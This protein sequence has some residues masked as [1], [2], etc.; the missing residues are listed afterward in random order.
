MDKAK[1]NRLLML[2]NRILDSRK[3]LVLMSRHLDNTDTDFFRY[4]IAMLEQEVEDMSRQIRYMKGECSSMEDLEP[5]YV[6][7]EYVVTEPANATATAKTE[8]SVSREVVASSV[9]NTSSQIMDT[10]EIENTYYDNFN[11]SVKTSTQEESNHD[12]E[13]TFGKSFMGIAASVLIFI[14]IVLFATLL[15]PMFGD[16]AKMAIMYAVSGAFL[17]IGA[18]RLNK[19]KD[20][21][22]NIALTGCGFGAMFISLL[23]S[24]IYFEVLGDIPLYVMI[25]IWGVI[26]CIFAKNKNFVFQI[27]GE[28]GIIVATVF[29]CILCVSGKDEARFLALL[30]FYGITSA[31][32]YFVNYEKEYED[33]I[34]YHGFAAIGGMVLTIGCVGI[35]GDNS[36]VCMIIAL[37]IQILNIVG[38][39][40]HRLD[41]PQISFGVITSLELFSV[42]IISLYV[43]E[44]EKIWGLVTYLIGMIMIFAVSMKK[45]NSKSG[46]ELISG[47]SAIVALIGLGANGTAYNYGV[48]FLM[49]IPLLVY[50]YVRKYSIS[51]Y[52]GLAIMGVYM[53]IYDGDIRGLHFVLMLVAFAV[54]YICMF[55]FKDQYNKEYKSLLHIGALLLIVSQMGDALWEILG[56]E[57]S[58]LDVVESI[59][60]VSFFVLNTICYKSRFVSNSITGEK[61]ENKEI[62][63][64]ANVFA[65]AMG[66]M[67]ISEPGSMGCH[68][69]NIL[70]ALAAFLIDTK[71]ILNKNSENVAGNVYIGGKF[72]VLLIVVLN[73]FTSPNYVISIACLV[74]A[75]LLILAGFKGEYKY[76]RIYGLGLTMISIFKLLM[77][78]I[79][80]A[81]TLGN[82][83]SFFVSGVLCFAISMIYN[84]LDKKMKR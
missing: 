1:L 62:Y 21:R 6:K 57:E 3:S 73:S 31:I 66:C 15:L 63:T 51:K 37:I 61:D 9:N 71:K 77:V 5:R 48:V 20:D 65:M 26:I 16:E 74:L 36:L 54:A 84:Y 76:L 56:R 11:S 50:G 27:I 8:D 67:L 24:N 58:S 53:F 38:I 19:D 59:V 22:F 23:L 4:K 17:G 41:K 29:G 12:F 69:V 28:I 45:A 35:A 64:I 13:K 49:I 39:M 70:V 46:L 75:I 42:A 33:N 7:K 14:S 32:F 83:I 10:F 2:E 60:Y 25:A 78:D 81:N 55:V 30:I 68:F 43:F 82:A 79:T 18:L 44:N 34:C 52:M 80:Y 47:A 40:S 72:T